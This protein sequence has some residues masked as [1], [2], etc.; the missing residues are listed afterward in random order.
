MRRDVVQTTVAAKAASSPILQRSSGTGATPATAGA[1]EA[2]AAPSR[3]SAPS[4][5][6]PLRPSLWRRRAAG[7]R[8]S[9]ALTF[10]TVMQELPGAAGARA[11]RAGAAAGSDGGPGGGGKGSRASPG[12]GGPGGSGR[13]PRAPR[14]AQPSQGVGGPAL[15]TGRAQGP[16][17]GARPPLFA[18]VSPECAFIIDE[19]LSPQEGEAGRKG[20]RERAWAGGRGE[21]EGPGTRYKGGGGGRRRRKRRPARCRVP[22]LRAGS[23]AAGHRRS[24]GPGRA[25][26]PAALTSSGPRTPGGRADGVLAPAGWAVGG[27]R[28]LRAPLAGTLV[29]SRA[30]RTRRRVG[31]EDRRA[32]PL[33]VRKARPRAW[34]AAGPAE[35]GVAA[36]GRAAVP[37]APAPSNS[38]SRV[39][40]CGCLSNRLNPIL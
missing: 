14:E 4:H 28:L 3:T 21:E 7:A 22:R 29:K 8:G 30:R 31:R 12:A 17:V 20:A 27:D 34:S 26:R 18:D 16:L 37:A 25:S 36:A 38:R 6:P 2:H 11:R 23:L 39:A 9:A 10:V 35:R 24:G 5:T 15:Q 1:K 32:G 19:P 33:E 13:A 40:E